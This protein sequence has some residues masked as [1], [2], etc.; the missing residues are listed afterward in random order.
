MNV[1]E[2]HDDILASLDQNVIGRLP[3]EMLDAGFNASHQAFIDQQL[4][5]D[6]SKGQVLVVPEL[7]QMA[8][9]KLSYYIKNITK[10]N[11]VLEFSLNTL[12]ATDIVRLLFDLDIQTP[13]GWKTP[14]IIQAKEKQLIV[15]NSHTHPTRVPFF[16]SYMYLS[17]RTVTLLVDS[18]VTVSNVRFTFLRNPEKMTH[19]ILYK[20]GDL[21][22]D[23]V[24][25][26]INS[27]M[28]TYN[29]TTYRR[30]QTLTIVDHTLF[31]AGEV[32]VGGTTSVDIDPQYISQICM[33]AAV[34][35]EKMRIA[36]IE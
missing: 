30:G 1:I 17:G 36:G 10:S 24:S 13:D 20:A 2:I 22:Q 29:G 6:G 3:V 28:V 31:T 34:L 27:P 14:T 21:T 11:T 8:M 25:V 26:L 4:G 33:N 18:T 7:F 15:D 9:N 23:N 16:I 35:V 12:A 5:V 32:L 19:G